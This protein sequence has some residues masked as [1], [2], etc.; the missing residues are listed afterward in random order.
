MQ[1][2]Y[3]MTPSQKGRK[4]EEKMQQSRMNADKQAKKQPGLLINQTSSN[5]RHSGSKLNLPNPAGVN[6]QGELL[7]CGVYSISKNCNN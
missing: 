5:R 2:A 6:T 7:F 1:N 4:V 3:K